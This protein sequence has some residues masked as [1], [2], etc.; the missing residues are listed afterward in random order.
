MKPLSCLD[1]DQ[2]LWRYIDRELS[3]SEIAAISVHLKNCEPCRAQ[4]HE[5]SREASQC[6]TVLSDTPFGEAFVG[7]LRQRM[8]DDGLFAS[9]RRSP[10]EALSFHRRRVRRIATVAAMLFLIPVVV[11]VGI[12]SNLKDPIQLGH[13]ATEGGAV[14]F[15]PAGAQ[16]GGEGARRVAAGFYGAGD[17]FVVPAGAVVTLRLGSPSRREDSLLKLT[18]PARFEIEPHA[19]KV[20]F[21]ARLA[22]G[23]LSADVA[24]R[25]LIEPFSIATEIARVGVLG[26]EFDL[27]ALDDRTE[28]RVRNGLVAFQGL[29]ALPGKATVRVTREKGPYVVMRGEVQ[30]VP[31][32]EADAAADA[33]PAP[34]HSAP[35]APG[36]D[37]AAPPAAGPEATPEDP[38]SARAIPGDRP[39]G[40]PGEPRPPAGD[41][42]GAGPGGSFDL[43]TPV[44]R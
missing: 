38:E 28:L 32:A 25:A 6:R 39:P 26:T 23:L 12:L 37:S 11:V 14:S 24:R 41:A 13:F 34:G 10:M 30:P 9:S 27:S 36:G 20:D 44:E 33:A 19:T 3:A 1:V 22:S 40:S 8:R 18:G 5:W 35:A 29:G 4:Y 43:D 17:A 21:R 2:S 42:P 31:L 15:V 16:P 7:R